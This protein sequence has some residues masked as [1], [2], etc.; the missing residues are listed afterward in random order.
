MQIFQNKI[1]QT[2][3]RHMTEYITSSRERGREKERTRR[4]TIQLTG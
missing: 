1:V 4:Y 3:K 2:L